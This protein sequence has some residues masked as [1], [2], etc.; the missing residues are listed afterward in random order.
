MNKYFKILLS[1]LFSIALTLGAVENVIKLSYDDVAD[2]ILNSNYFLS[3]DNPP[4]PIEKKYNLEFSIIKDADKKPIEDSKITMTTIG[5]EAFV[6]INGIYFNL[7]IVISNIIVKKSK[8]Q[9]NY[10]QM[11]R[12]YSPKKEQ[13]IDFYDI[14]ELFNNLNVR[15]NKNVNTHFI[16]TAD[17]PSN[18]Y[19]NGI[20]HYKQPSDNYNNY[21]YEFNKGNL[22]LSAAYHFPPIEYKY[23]NILMLSHKAGEKGYTYFELI[24]DNP[25][26]LLK[27]IRRYG[28]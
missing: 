20:Y 9:F 17:N 18:I 27:T 28:E 15:I 13:I 19:T 14:H 11:I 4:N 8:K 2:I 10:I 7:T 23:K 5:Y 12:L 6:E 3:Y 16:D 26:R 21:E 25:F 1:L 22:I 24:F